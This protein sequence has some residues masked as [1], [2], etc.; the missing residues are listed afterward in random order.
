M[1]APMFTP[2]ERAMF[3]EVAEMEEKPA[4]RRF[5]K[6]ILDRYVP[7]GWQGKKLELPPQDDGQGA[8]TTGNTE[9]AARER[10]AEAA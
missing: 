9:G 10:E 8:D 1:S 3:D 7:I 5:S 4:T 6:E 2:A